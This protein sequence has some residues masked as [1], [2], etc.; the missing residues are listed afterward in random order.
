MLSRND[1]VELYKRYTES[2]SLFRHSL[3]VEAVM[4]H[5]AKKWGE[6][7]EYWGVVGLLHDLDYEKFPDEHCKKA[8]ELLRE[9]GFDDAFIH[10]VVS[11]G[12]GICVDVAPELR[13]EKALYA[14]DELTGLIAAAVLMLP[15]KD[16]NDLKLSS[17]KKKWKDK[18]FAAGVD[19]SVIANGAE[20]LGM[21]VEELMVETIEG[22]KGM[23]AA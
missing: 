7:E 8:P 3:A 19:R 2:E 21:T 15:S 12:Y 5:F 13:M 18:K 9:A 1:A 6:D 17:L 10:A 11:H 16:I 22:M 4:R 20:M 23:R 14:S